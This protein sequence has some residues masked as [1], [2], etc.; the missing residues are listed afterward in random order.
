MGTLATKLIV[1]SGALVT[2]AVSACSGSESGSGDAVVMSVKQADSDP[3]LISASNCVLRGSRLTSCAIA[4]RTIPG[5]V[6]ETAVPLRTVFTVH[7]SGN[8]S[9]QY[10]LEVTLSQPGEPD[11]KLQYL[12]TP[13]VAVRRRDG[14]NIPFINLK[15]SSSWTK[16]AALDASC[17]ITLSSA[18]NQPDVDTKEQAQAIIDALTKDLA[19]KTRIRDRYSDL[20]SYQKAFD[21]LNAY[22]GALYTELTNDAMQKLRAD[23]QAAKPVLMKMVGS[24]TCSG[25]LSDGDLSAV[26][27]LYESLA[28]LGD[29]ASWQNDAGKTMTLAEKMGPEAAKIVDV[30][31]K[32]SQAHSSDA[33]TGYEAEYNQAAQDVQRA[34][35]KLNLA[36]KQLANWLNP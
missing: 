22:V 5:L 7:K 4:D 25:T 11:V 1:L 10:P 20:I 13:S 15:D 36:K 29:P 34:T 18:W 9:T 35:D 21:F 12:S 28:A 19:D 30:A 17:M 3:V 26:V 33:G 32:L 27:S 2:C 14:Q 6:V 31:K 23:G 16:Y 8:C 24:D